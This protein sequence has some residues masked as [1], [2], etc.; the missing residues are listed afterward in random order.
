MNLL[1]LQDTKLTH[2]NFLYTT[3]EKEIKMIRRDFPLLKLSRRNL[4]KKGKRGRDTVYSKS[5]TQVGT[6]K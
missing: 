1:K 5:T 4:N 6:H 2:I 3:N